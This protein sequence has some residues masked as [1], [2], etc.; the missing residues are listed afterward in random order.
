M[1]KQSMHKSPVRIF[2]F[3]EFNLSNNKPETTAA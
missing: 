1:F 3:G 2:A